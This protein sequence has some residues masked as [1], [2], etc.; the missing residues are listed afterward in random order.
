[1]RRC[2]CAVLTAVTPRAGGEVAV[3]A[4]AGITHIHN[5]A[6]LYC[7][8]AFVARGTALSRRVILRGVAQVACDILPLRV[9]PPIIF[10]ALVYWQAG[11]HDHPDNFIIFG[12][13]ITL[14]SVWCVRCCFGVRTFMCPRT[15]P[16]VNLISAAVCLSVGALVRDLCLANLAAS[17][18]LL[19]QLLL[20]GLLS[21][22]SSTG[23]TLST[24]QRMSFMN[25]AFEI[26]GNNEF[27]GAPHAVPRAAWAL[28]HELIH[29]WSQ[30][31]RST[32]PQLCRTTKLFHPYVLVRVH[33]QQYAHRLSVAT[34][35][36][37]G[38]GHQFPATGEVSAGA[39]LR[40]CVATS[41]CCM[42]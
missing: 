16:Q 19:F 24:F 36:C 7:K 27:I 9:L 38:G 5:G 33:V 8:G 29:L 30:A 1:M 39:V 34:C 28:V 18:V 3:F 42:R 6:V 4:R 14:V 2:L 22:N 10:S 17:L 25:Y 12:V 21:H 11:L 32:C 23:T 13:V 41:C 20:C 26:L 31:K 35:T 37:V 15:A 40:W